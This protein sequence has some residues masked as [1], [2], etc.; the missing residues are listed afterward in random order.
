MGRTDPGSAVGCN[1]FA[2]VAGRALMREI[3]HYTISN[4]G[5][6]KRTQL[7]IQAG[8]PKAHCAEGS[9]LD[10]SSPR[11]RSKNAIDNQWVMRM[12]LSP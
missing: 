6:A 9:N 3:K 8:H 1:P 5:L 12:L 10:Q 7:G 11:G 4:C 2:G